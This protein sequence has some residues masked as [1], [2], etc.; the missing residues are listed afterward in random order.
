[1]QSRKCP[2][3]QSPI[4]IRLFPWNVAESNMLRSYKFENDDALSAGQR[5][6]GMRYPGTKDINLLVKELSHS[7]L[8]ES[9]NWRSYDCLREDKM[10][11]EQRLP[12]EPTFVPH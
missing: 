11:P 12:A 2:P 9:V 6:Y 7:L 10:K 1:M 8:K 4:R 5:L 3:S